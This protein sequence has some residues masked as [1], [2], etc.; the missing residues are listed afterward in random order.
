MSKKL[1]KTA[2]SVFDIMKET[3]CRQITFHYN[4]DTNLELIWVIDSIPDKRNKKG[5]LKL[6]VSVSG[7]TRYAHNDA[8]I[9][10]QDVLKLARAMTRKS[11]VLG[12]KEGGGKA[13]VLAKQKKNK[14]FLQVIG[15]FIQMHKGLFKTAIDLGFEMRDGKQ[16]AA[17]TDFVDSLSHLEKGLGSTGENTAE[18]MLY[19]FEVIAKEFLNKP[20]NK[21]SVAIQGLGAVGQALAKRL[22]SLGCEV[23][24]ADQVKENQEKARKMGVKIVSNDKVLFQKVDILAPCALGG[25]INKETRSK[26][27]CKVVAGGANNP[28]ANELEDEKYLL[29][30]KIIYIPDFVINCGGFLQALIERN[31]GSVEKARKRANIVGQKLRQVTLY[32]KRN[33]ISLLEAALELFDRTR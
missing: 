5:K 7:G 23:L 32:S 27:K 24:V 8:D 15:D 30:R 26:L 9:A 10:L 25:V 16:I 18:G 4:P 1:N 13:V 28:L 21:C 17:K 20:L 31:G 22:I 29:K 11:K 6:D 2:K 19:G 33:K 14:K 12:V 3:E